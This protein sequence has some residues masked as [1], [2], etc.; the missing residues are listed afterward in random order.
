MVYLFCSEI[1]SRS[2]NEIHSLITQCN[3]KCIKVNFKL[4]LFWFFSFSFW[5]VCIMYT[6]Y[7]T[8][9]V[10]YLRRKYP[11]LKIFFFH[12]MF[13]ILWFDFDSNSYSFHHVIVVLLYLECIPKTF[14]LL[15]G[16]WEKTNVWLRKDLLFPLRFLILKIK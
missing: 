9:C 15:K 11:W 8:V 1:I 6:Y 5:V 7:R 16:S 13:S 10:R 3:S 4:I 12:L 2:E 14:C